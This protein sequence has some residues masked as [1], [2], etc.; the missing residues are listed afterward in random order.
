MVL[1]AFFAGAMN[2]VAGGG[3]FLTLPALMLGGVSP[4]VANAT[5]T[6]ALFPGSF[7]SAYSYREEI[8]GL[9]QINLKLWLAIGVAGG[10][11]G[12]LLL[13]YTS[14]NTFLKITP[15]LLLFATLLFLFGR[16]VNAFLQERAHFSQFALLVILFLISVYGGYFGGGMGIMMLAVFS[17]YGLTNIHAMNGVKAMMGGSL[18][19]M[20]VV[21][22]V[23]AHQISWLPALTM[24]AAGIAGGYCGPIVARRFPQQYIRLFVVFIGCFMTVYFF[25]KAPK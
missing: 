23:L 21:V 2:S 20:A 7:A 12:A 4:V 16:Q 25:A 1:A 5:S 18:N 19:A 15:W 22:F 17:L 8:K 10:L 24:M 3:S 11:A 9:A 6:V 13:M 14:D